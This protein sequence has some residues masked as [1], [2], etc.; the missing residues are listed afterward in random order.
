MNQEV[1][2]NN[3]EQISYTLARQP[4]SQTIPMPGLYSVRRCTWPCCGDWDS[5]RGYTEGMGELDDVGAVAGKEG[6]RGEDAG[7]EGLSGNERIDG[8][9]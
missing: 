9:A 8:D 4:S 2:H 3:R 7:C 1:K 5:R 6:V